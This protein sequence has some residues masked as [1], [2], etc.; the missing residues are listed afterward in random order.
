M[1]SRICRYEIQILSQHLYRLRKLMVKMVWKP[2]LEPS[3]STRKNG[4]H[5]NRQLIYILIHNSNVM[6]S[7]RI[8]LIAEF[9][10]RLCVRM[11]WHDNFD[12]Q[13]LELPAMHFAQWLKF[14]SV[15]VIKIGTQA[16][17]PSHF[18]RRM[19][20]DMVHS[21]LKRIHDISVIDWILY[22]QFRIVIRSHCHHFIGKDFAEQNIYP[23]RMR[24]VSIALWF[25]CFDVSCWQY[26]FMV[27]YI[28]HYLTALNWLRLNA[29]QS[30][31]IG[32][33]LHIC[34]YVRNFNFAAWI[35]AFVLLSACRKA[36]NLSTIET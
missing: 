27:Y 17:I 3:E 6:H 19:K 9:C 16:S 26:K 4:S 21:I 1:A 15:V 30:S 25:Q 31:Q 18:S 5:S 14:L 13:C 36:S 8:L 11:A 33:L 24:F 34:V 23:H 22:R 2:E 10:S 7:K 12:L 32:F 35:Y 28:H 20:L 29:L